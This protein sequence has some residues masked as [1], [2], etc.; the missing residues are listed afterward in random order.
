[1]VRDDKG[2]CGPTTLE[3]QRLPVPG[4]NSKEFK[5]GGNHNNEPKAQ[6]RLTVKML[7]HYLR[8]IHKKCLQLFKEH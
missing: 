7:L 8:Y 6:I 2:C 1:M 4:L 5:V 3:S